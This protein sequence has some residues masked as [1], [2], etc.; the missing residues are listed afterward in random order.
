[1][2]HWFYANNDMYMCVVR[3][4]QA[5]EKTY[6]GLV[7]FVMHTLLDVTELWIKNLL[8]EAFSNLNWKHR[9]GE[10]SVTKISAELESLSRDINE[11]KRVLTEREQP[12]EKKKMSYHTS[13]FTDSRLG[14]IL[15]SW[16]DTVNAER[17]GLRSYRSF[18]F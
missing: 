3:G 11:I 14:T 12:V 18:L 1:M 10:E 6:K 2:P 16:G 8:E 5:A 7:I 4:A 9:D 17:Y 13:S 15:S